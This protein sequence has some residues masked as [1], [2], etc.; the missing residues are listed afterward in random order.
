MTA[1]LAARGTALTLTRRDGQVALHY[2]G[3]MAYDATG[4]ELPTWLELRGEELLL[5]VNDVAARYPLTVDPFVQL[6]ELTASDGAA[7]DQLGFS[8]A[9]SGDTVVVGAP[10]AKIGNNVWQG[11]AY[12]FV[13]P[14][15]GAWAPAAETA[16][17][18]A[19]DGAGS[20]RFGWSVAI[21]GDTVVVAGLPRGETY[22]FVKPGTGWAST[23][24]TARLTGAASDHFGDSVAISGDT[25]VVG[26]LG[27]SVSQGAA[28]V[29]VKPGTG[30][31]TTSTFN[32]ELTA[33]DG[34]ASA[35]F[36]ESVAIS[37]DTVVVGDSRAMI[38]NNI[39]GAAYVFVKPGTEWATTS[40]FN[41]KL[42]ASD[43]AVGAYF[44]ESVAI[45]GDTVV[46]GAYAAWVGNNP[47]QGTAYVFVKPE[48]GAWAPTTETAKLTA[49]DGAARDFFGMSVAISGDTVVVGAPTGG[50]NNAQGAAYVFVKPGTGAWAATMETA[51]LTA[52]DGAANDAFGESVAI[53]GDIVVVGANYFSSG[54][55][56]VPAHGTAYVFG[57]NQIAP[58][59]S[60]TGAPASAA[61]G[62]TFNVTATTNAS[63]TAVITASGACSI[64]GDTVTMTSSA[65]TCSLTASWA[66]DAHYTAA[67]LSQS[68][69]ATKTAPTVSFT[70][71]PASAAYGA[72]F[73]V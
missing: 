14:E 6:A 7:G 42:T 25:V 16:R 31:A 70:G 50:N 60:F 61:Y 51:R 1:A 69:T 44:G 56:P 47:L 65:G 19:S 66:A 35:V 41:A 17:L 59:V 37:G 63:T 64:T 27:N 57:F 26:A 46:V 29:F 43:G 55:P 73:N 48:T 2:G 18:T 36:G 23:T 67:S 30:W 9:I 8:V 34:A 24:E 45:S 4:R 49:S 10:S 40:T 15:T 62:A 53:S 39:Q 71:A 33:S 54:Y 12:V 32:A 3:L 28:Y 20:D 72:T 11:A 38:G 13:K 68:T 58:T 21:S 52:S 22:V 5:R